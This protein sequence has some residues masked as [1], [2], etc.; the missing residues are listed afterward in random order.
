MGGGKG[1][2]E[3]Q[4]AEYYLTLDYG[5]CHGPLDS[6]NEIWIKEKKVWEGFVSQ[7]STLTLNKPDAFGGKKKEGGVVGK[8]D[9][10]MG[11]STQKMTTAS[12]QRYGLTPDTMP[13]YRGI[14]HLMFRGSE[15]SQ[16]FLWIMNNPYLPS[17]W[18]TPTRIP[19]GW[20]ENLSAIPRGEI[21][22]RSIYFL[23]DRSASLSSSEFN[24]IKSAVL[25][26]LTFIEL[27]M[28][29]GNR[30][31][32][33]VYFWSSGTGDVSIDRTDIDAADLDDIRSFIN[34]TGQLTGGNVVPAYTAAEAWFQ[35]T[36]NADLAGRS[37]ILVTDANSN[38]G[39]S[40]AASGPAADML[41]QSSGEFSTA[42][43]NP[44]DLYS[45]NF[46]NDA[47]AYT[48]QL[49]NTPDDGVPVIDGSDVSGLSNAVRRAILSG[50]V[51]DAN[52]A[53]MI[54]ECLTNGEWGLGVLDADI[55]SSF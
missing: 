36:K 31:D 35:A 15:D 43:G 1:K 41:D 14:S 8:V 32:I 20:Q 16:G 48:A 40:S 28:E 53:H 34:S 38:D 23:L 3:Y 39:F 17:T 7:N 37:L 49:D 33:G 18:V 19:K 24:A 46:A 30:V 2:T 44:V 54:R 5:L 52:P 13:G 45:I 21:G 29:L 25:D 42:N 6:I 51:L 10:Y 9:V 12:A 26:S 11:T 50:L 55:G 22:D 27:A 47:T 4:V